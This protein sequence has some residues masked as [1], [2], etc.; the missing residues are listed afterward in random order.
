VAKQK[1][2]LQK[3]VVVIENINITFLNLCCV[4]N[5]LDHIYKRT[6]IPSVAVKGF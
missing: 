2:D 1:V 4:C 6:S 3:I 5:R